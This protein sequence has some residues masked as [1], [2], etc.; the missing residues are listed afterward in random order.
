MKVYSY[1]QARQ[2][3]SEVLDTA[4][5]LTVGPGRSAV[6]AWGDVGHAIRRVGY[7]GVPNFRDPI[8][9][10]CVRAMGWLN[11]C[12][13]D[14]LEAAD[15][16]RFC[17]LYE[18]RQAEQRKWDVSEPSKLL[19]GAS[20]VERRLNAPMGI[21]L[22]ATLRVLGELDDQNPTAS[23]SAIRGGPPRPFGEAFGKPGSK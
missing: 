4:A 8:V 5:D 16:A 23:P 10:Y 7:I 1:S 6:D 3:F 15:R 22:A 11:L 21:S 2:H 12:K 13:G 18:H 20:H 19:P 14:S 9:D 17:E